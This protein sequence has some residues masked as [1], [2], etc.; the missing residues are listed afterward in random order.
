MWDRKSGTLLDVRE[1]DEFDEDE[2]PLRTSLLTAF[3]PPLSLAIA[4]LTRG[5]RFP[6]P[7]LTTTLLP[8]QIY[9][10][11]S[12]LIP[13]LLSPSHA[14]RLKHLDS[15][16]SLLGWIARLSWRNSGKNAI[17]YLAPDELKEDMGLAKGR[18]T[19]QVPLGVGNTG[20]PFSNFLDYSGGN[21]S[22]HSIA[23]VVGT[24]SS[25]GGGRAQSD[26]E[27]G[28]G[29]APSRQLSEI[30]LNAIGGQLELKKVAQ[31]RRIVGGGGGKGR[32][33]CEIV[34][35]RKEDGW[36]G[37]GNTVAGWSE[38]SRAV[39]LSPLPSLSLTDQTLNPGDQT[40][41]PA[42]LHPQHSRRGIHLP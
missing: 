13:L 39:R 21:N 15:L 3:V 24:R 28:N 1:M 16:L 2:I 10:L 14:R 27:K 18:S 33:K 12:S 25:A 29:V 9:I 6:S 40:P 41:S 36:C 32:G 22:P 20:K 19:T 35:W 37:R 5:D 23:Q 42:Y 7:S 11:S 26:W 17:G 31:R 38:M 34:I 4:K 8:T 30:N